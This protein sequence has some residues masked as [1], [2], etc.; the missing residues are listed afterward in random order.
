MISFY[1]GPS[2]VEERIPEY[3]QDAYNEGI[4]SINHRSD[5]FMELAK[6]TVRELKTKLSIPEDYSVFFASAATECW[7]IIAQ[8]LV[9]NESMHFFNGA[10]G[11]K[12]FKYTKKITTNAVERPFNMDDLLNPRELEIPS[13]TDVICLTQNETS[14]GTQVHHSTIGKINDMYP[15][16]LIAVDATSSMAGVKLYFTNADVWYAS[17]QKCFG[18]PAGLAV[19]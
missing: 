6:D 8:S 18:L 19:M 11:E 15:D 2:R 4:L 13:A 12:W 16:P 10:F 7:E 3:V 5:E 1:P 9:K 17:V 14:N